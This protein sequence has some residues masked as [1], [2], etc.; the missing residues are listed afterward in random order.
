MYKVKFELNQLIKENSDYKKLRMIFWISVIWNFCKIVFND[1]K[2]G[3][4][5]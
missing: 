5:F 3:W 1:N 2:D 4:S